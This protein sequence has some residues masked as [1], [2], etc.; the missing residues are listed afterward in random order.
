MVKTVHRLNLS[1][2]IRDCLGLHVST[3]NAIVQD[4]DTK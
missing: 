4:R 2:T 3:K 1:R